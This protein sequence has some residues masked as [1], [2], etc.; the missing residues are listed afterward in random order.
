MEVPIGF[1]ISVVLP[2]PSPPDRPRAPRRT[3]SSTVEWTKDA[4]QTIPGITVA[5]GCNASPGG[6]RAQ[7]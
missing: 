5:A 2:F 4:A 1:L 3:E 6:S 7:L